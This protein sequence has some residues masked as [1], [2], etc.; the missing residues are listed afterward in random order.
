M[1]TVCSIVLYVHVHVGVCM[2][3]MY[4][5]LMCM[6]ITAGQYNIVGIGMGTSTTYTYWNG[7][8]LSRKMTV[9]LKKTAR[10]G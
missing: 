8:F 9:V 6:V 7:N 4:T 1:H 5:N 2:M 3:K 10:T